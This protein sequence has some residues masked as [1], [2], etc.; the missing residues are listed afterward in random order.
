MNTISAR[1]FSIGS[2]LLALLFLA[3]GCATPPTRPGLRA[4]VKSGS[5]VRVTSVRV[6]DTSKGVQIS[7]T[8]GSTFGYYQSPRRH[9]D[10]EV[11][12]P[13]GRLSSRTPVKFFPN[14]I[15][16]SRFGHPH[17][18]FAITLPEPPPVG[19]TVRVAV[20][21]TSIADCRT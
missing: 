8:V 5:G 6:S 14:P 21:A 9:L 3:D 7:G 17:S 10:I 1:S 19:S 18:S 20:H 12:G 4:T 13:D 15:R 16:H 11:L 2:I